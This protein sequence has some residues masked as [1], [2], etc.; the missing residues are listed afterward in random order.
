MSLCSRLVQELDYLAVVF[1]LHATEVKK[2]SE[3]DKIKALQQ[4]KDEKKRYAAPIALIGS[5]PRGSI[6]AESPHVTSIHSHWATVPWL[7]FSVISMGSF[8]LGHQYGC[9]CQQVPLLIK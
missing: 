8:S 1:Q 2:D 3:E 5:Q 4:Q 7:I 6:S 9:S